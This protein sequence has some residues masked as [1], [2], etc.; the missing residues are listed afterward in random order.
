MNRRRL[1]ALAGAGVF[2]PSFVRT[3]AAAVN[4]PGFEYDY[5]ETTANVSV[6]G[7]AATP[8]LI[9]QGNPRSFDGITRVRVEWFAQ[10][11]ALPAGYF[12][13][14]VGL[15]DGEQA[16]TL[17][18]GMSS[19]DSVAAPNNTGYGAALFTPAAGEHLYSIRGYKSPG[20]GPGAA[21]VGASGLEGTDGY[22]PCYYR[23]TQA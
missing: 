23:V 17:L 10:V 14:N 22:G 7:L 5:A 21:I 12:D 15:W 11:I 18:V 3:A 19:H 4:P 6:R 16:V 1:L 8:T 9:T 2:A 13:L 20:S